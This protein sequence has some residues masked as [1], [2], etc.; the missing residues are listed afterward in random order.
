MFT[1]FLFLCYVW[2][3]LFIISYICWHGIKEMGNICIIITQR[4]DLSRDILHW[5][6][7][8]SR[9]THLSSPAVFH[10]FNFTDVR[11]L[12]LYLSVGWLCLSWLYAGLLRG[13]PPK[14]NKRLGASGT[15]RTTM[16][17]LIR[18][19]GMAVDAYGATIGCWFN[20][21]GVIT[22]ADREKKG[23]TWIKRLNTKH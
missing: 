3:C 11:Q 6:H 7:D 5:P 16:T 15:K 22:C 21:K 23:E 17:A 13:C 2:Y 9:D 1:L 18:I 20:Y 14:L 4:S 10:Q 19:R 12:L 8:V